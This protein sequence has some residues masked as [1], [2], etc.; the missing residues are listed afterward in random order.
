M[1]IPDVVRDDHA[2]A[3]TEQMEYLP[4]W[5]V[6]S[7]SRMGACQ[8]DACRQGRERCPCPEACRELAEPDNGVEFIGRLLLYAALVVALVGT[9]AVMLWVPR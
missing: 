1:I 7:M 8:A 3:K 9:V 2:D 5:Y 6:E 4:R